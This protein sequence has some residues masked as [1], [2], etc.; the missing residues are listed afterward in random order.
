MISK[1]ELTEKIAAIEG[2][3]TKKLAKEVVDTVF[4]EI[5]KSLAAGEEVRVFDFGTFKTAER[6]A[7]TAFNPQTKEKVPVPAKTVVKFSA[8]KSLKEAVNAPKKG[9]GKKKK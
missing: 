7:T 5:A 4:A 8:S 6:A 2:I 1:K 9:K 3:G